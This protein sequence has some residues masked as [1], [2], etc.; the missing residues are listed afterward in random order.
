MPKFS[1]IFSI[2]MGVALLSTWIVM[3][4]SGR[5]PEL[6]TQPVQTMFLLVA[7]ILTGA[8]L[9]L[10]GY[11]VL[12]GARWGQPANLIALGMLVYCSI[13]YFGV[14]C[15]QGNIPAAI[16]M[17][18]VTVAALFFSFAMLR[19]SISNRRLVVEGIG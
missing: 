4:L 9:I 10:S 16:F 3:I 19:F 5:V 14:L 2:L 15:Q 7:E 11:G 18:L 12:A 8:S 6:V 13:N 1:A 17:G